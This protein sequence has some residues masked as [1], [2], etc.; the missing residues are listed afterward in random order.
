MVVS[1]PSNSNSNMCLPIILAFLVIIFVFLL[2]MSVSARNQ[3][4]IE[5]FYGEESS[6]TIERPKAALW[7]GTLNGEDVIYTKEFPIKEVENYADKVLHVARQVKNGSVLVIGTTIKR[8]TF[9]PVR[10]IMIPMDVSEE[11]VE[12][13]PY[14]TKVTVYDVTKGDI[15]NKTNLSNIFNSSEE[16]GVLT[17]VRVVPFAAPYPTEN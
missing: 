11:T 6:T 17:K 16:G 14:L 5:Q 10:K 2:I 7:G 13:Q 1:K 4:K 9:E 15:K 8:R 3:A 12:N